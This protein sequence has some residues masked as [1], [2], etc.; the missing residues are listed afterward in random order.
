MKKVL[1]GVV[2]MALLASCA[3]TEKVDKD[4]QLTNGWSVEQL[5][6]EAN[7][8]L[9]SKNYVRAIKLYDILIGRYP[10]GRF[11]EQAMLDKAY[12]YYRYEEKELALATIAEFQK[13][14]P[15]HPRMDYVLYLKG[16]AEFDQKNES[17]LDRLSDQNWAERDPKSAKKSYQVFQELVTQFPDS[18]YVF[19][20]KQR[21]HDL[22]EAMGGHEIAVARYYY[23]MGAFVAAANRAQTVLNDY[24]NTSHIEEALAIMMSCYQRLDQENLASDSRRLLELNYPESAFLVKGQ[25]FDRNLKNPWQITKDAFSRATEMF[26][27]DNHEQ[28][29]QDQI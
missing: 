23:K 20:A 6:T 15:K 27:I 21:M 7:D 8:E 16:L 11:A 5:Y 29:V 4:A 19:D 9:T 12:A 25:W 13:L 22:V 24:K 1:L 3:S 26:K 17:F 14:Y 18:Q 2:L 10:Y 28:Q